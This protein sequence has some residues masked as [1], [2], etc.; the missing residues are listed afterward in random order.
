MSERGV[1]SGKSPEDTQDA[2]DLY[3]AL[4]PGFTPP[5]DLRAA[6]RR[7][8]EAIRGVTNE[9]EPEAAT[10]VL[11][12]ARPESSEEESPDSPEWNLKAEELTLA[13]WDM[14]ERAGLRIWCR[15]ELDPNHCWYG[16]DVAYALIQQERN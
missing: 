2:Q 13:G 7:A 1:S 9:T 3:E 12:F 11:P 16:E 15:N 4:L 8:S 6:Q 14:L 5:V 10:A